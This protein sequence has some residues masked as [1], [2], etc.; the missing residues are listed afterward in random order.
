MN[1]HEGSADPRAKVQSLIRKAVAMAEEQLGTS[2]YEHMEARA[3]TGAE[4]KSFRVNQPYCFH[5]ACRR[6]V[7]PAQQAL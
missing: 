1:T 4:W 5:A 6:P 2:I 3:P 7:A